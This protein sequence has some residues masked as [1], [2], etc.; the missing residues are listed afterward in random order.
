MQSA[1]RR[2]HTRRE[3]RHGGHSSST[4]PNPGRRRCAHCENLKLAER[5]REKGKGLSVQT[6]PCA[7]LSLKQPGY[8]RRDDVLGVGIIH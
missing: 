7:S 5:E 8:S 1:A 3:S 2:R 6:A 4:L